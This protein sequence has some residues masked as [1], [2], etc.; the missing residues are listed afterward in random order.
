MNL[1]I[2]VNV[3]ALLTSYL[4]TFSFIILLGIISACTDSIDNHGRSFRMA[5]RAEPPTLDWSLATDSISFN[6]LTNLMEG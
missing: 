6:I 1:M 3:K 2:P 4:R 5:V